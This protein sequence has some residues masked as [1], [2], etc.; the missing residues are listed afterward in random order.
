MKVPSPEFWLKYHAAWIH[1][2]VDQLHAEWKK[3]SWTEEAWIY[4][5]V[6]LLL[7]LFS[8]YMAS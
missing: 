2:H 8:M 4:A 5:D 6:A 3:Q 1:D 7:I